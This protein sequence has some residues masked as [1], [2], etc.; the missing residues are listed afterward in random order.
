[1]KIIVKLLSFGL[2]VMGVS[3]ADP[4]SYDLRANIFQANV[5]SATDTNWTNIDAI[6]LQTSDGWEGPGLWGGSFERSSNSVGGEQKQTIHAG[7]DAY[8][9]NSAT[10]AEYTINQPISI[11]SYYGLAD[12]QVYNYGSVRF[13]VQIKEGDTYSTILDSLVEDSD[14]WRYFEYD[15]TPWYD[16]EI[17]LRMITDPYGWT[18]EDWAHWSESIVVM[19]YTP[20]KVYV[21]QSGD[22]STGN[23]SVEYPYASIQ[24]GIEMAFTT[25]T[26]II[27]NGTYFENLYIYG[28]DL[29]IKSINGPEYCII[30]GNQLDRVI[31]IENCNLSLSGFSIVNGISEWYGGGM[32]VKGSNIEIDNCIFANNQV[33]NY[34][35]ARGGGFYYKQLDST[36][37][38][39][40]AI[41]NCVFE[42]N[43]ADNN[44]GGAGFQ[45]GYED[46]SGLDIIIENCDFINNMADSRGA[47]RIDGLNTNFQINNCNFIGNQVSRHTSAAGFYNGSS[48]IVNNSSFIENISSTSDEYDDQNGAI[49][50]YGASVDFIN[51][52]FAYN[53]ADRAS[54]LFISGGGVAT[55]TNSI[56]WG[57]NIAQIYVRSWEGVP[58]IITVNYC[59]ILNGIDSVSVDSISILNWGIGNIDSN[60]LFCNPDS[61]EYTLAENSPC[62][63]TGENAAN[64]GAYDIGCDSMSISNG[65]LTIPNKFSLYH[66]YPNP[67]NPKTTISFQIPEISFVNLSI[68]NITGKL[69]TTLVNG[70]IQSGLHTAQWDAKNVS[71]GVYF[72]KITTG[73]YSDTGKC[74]LLK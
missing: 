28:K 22:D 14:Y 45:T 35:W 30:D 3:Q 38:Y 60:P 52:T 36:A 71:S 24:W 21:S 15:L 53:I 63:G 17:T 18:A 49:G 6:Y 13:I 73:K 25:D 32:S 23:G 57:E 33:T 39:D 51:C 74:I 58:G 9:T 64:I 48:G 16:S 66:N 46:S 1:M 47:I 7:P 67:F 11:S 54:S 40:V 50:M 55:L 43:M 56:L 37:T 61:G 41:I 70:Q 42:N 27:D 65:N 2:F 12:G 29:T 44:S 20:T 19:D 4:I 8:E 10:V 26:L 5:Y 59:D 62:I 68:Y 34:E 69:V 31:E 72:Y